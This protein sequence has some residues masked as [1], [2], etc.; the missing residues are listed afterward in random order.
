ME[1]KK[2]YLYQGIAWLTILLLTAGSF[3]IEE[4]VEAI[5]ADPLIEFNVVYN[6]D[7]TKASIVFDL[8]SIDQA[9]NEIIKI[10]SERDGEV[11]YDRNL[12]NQSSNYDVDENGNYQ[13]MVTYRTTSL[14]VNSI[15]VT[16]DESESIKTAQVN[17]KVENIQPSIE[18]SSSEKPAPADS[19]EEV[20]GTNEEFNIETSDVSSNM[21]GSEDTDFTD[22]NQDQTEE[23]TT[24]KE[25]TDSNWS[26]IETEKESQSLSKESRDT[27]YPQEILLKGL[28][29]N[30][31]A[32]K[33][34]FVIDPTTYQFKGV[35]LG[36]VGGYHQNFSGTYY[37]IIAY[38]SNAQLHDPG[39]VVFEVKGTDR[40]NQSN[41]TTIE[42]FDFEEG[43][44]IRIWSA[45]SK[46][47]FVGAPV[48]GSDGVSTIDY[49]T[50]NVPWER[51][52]NSVYQITSQGLKEIYNSA[53]IA[54]GQDIPLYSLYGQGDWSDGDLKIA[55]IY[56]DMVFR[57]DRDEQGIYQS[58]GYTINEKIG[59]INYVVTN[60]PADDIVS[61]GWTTKYTVTDSWGRQTTINRLS[62]KLPKIDS[63]ITIEEME[64]KMVDGKKVDGFVHFPGAT[65]NT[66]D[67]TVTLSSSL[68]INANPQW[69]A[70]LVIPYGATEKTRIIKSSTGD[71]QEVDFAGKYRIP[72]DHVTSVTIKKDPVTVIATDYQVNLSE[73]QIVS[74]EETALKEKIKEQL[75]QEIGTTNSELSDAEIVLDTTLDKVNPKAGNYQATLKLTN[76]SGTIE[77]TFNLEVTS[78]PWSYDT[79]ERTETNGASGFVVIPKG[80]DL[81][82]DHN[83]PSQL[84]ATAEVYFANYG[85]AT[86]VNYQVSVDETFEMMNV[87]DTSNKFTVTA[88]AANNQT[89][90]SNGQLALGNLSTTNTKGNGLSVTFTAPTDKVDRTKGRWQGNVQFYI[91]RQ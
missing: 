78:N 23:T 60:R 1:R 58:N 9:T 26:N 13:F 76:T 2:N 86:G 18:T 56:S 40:P 81:Q 65:V 43:D 28:V 36:T 88:T 30:G 25:T 68:V 52:T 84:S 63:K 39:T 32:Q 11:V 38:K 61:G 20:G 33:V 59:S 49:S 29:G 69:E 71:L 87:V 8:E 22:A 27:T 51:F 31:N 91:E 75:A 6:E 50:R 90:A 82:R 66:K 62:I 80:I 67:Q 21:G 41:F 10:T 46:F 17:V 15:K 73:T 16:S 79:P 45:E 19:G 37:K 24:V 5:T 77:Q 57:D 74:L 7:H 89:G 85:N 3:H 44:M 34:K 55:P 14:L 53:P 42:A 12:I 54:T 70:C 4:I 83:N 47:N 48:I 64:E 72:A 35:V